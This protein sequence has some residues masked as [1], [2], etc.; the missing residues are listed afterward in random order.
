MPGFRTIAD[1]AP[2]MMWISGPDMRPTWFNRRWLEFVG[3]TLEEEIRDQGRGSVHPEDL[4]ARLDAYERSFAA[5]CSF[6]VEYRL[7]R[8][9]GEWR[10]VLDN[11]APNFAGGHL[12]RL[13]RHLHRH[14]R[15][16]RGAPRSRPA[17]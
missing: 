4:T 14:Y 16:Q 1:Q 17:P 11:G 9:D 8:C 5:R 6:D 13:P 3:H 7:L 2:V 10:W 15:A 12:R